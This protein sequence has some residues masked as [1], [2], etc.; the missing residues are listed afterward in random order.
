VIQK[1]TELG[2]EKLLLTNSAYS[3][4]FDFEFLEKKLSRWKKIMASACAQSKNPFLPKILFGSHNEICET[5]QKNSEFNLICLD[6]HM[7]KIDFSNI[8]KYKEKNIIIF[9]GPEGGYS[10]EEIILFE[11]YNIEKINI[12]KYILRTETAS[13]VGAFLAQILCNN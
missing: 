4:K 5:Y 9:I 8:R 12:N 6:P 3:K 1:V 10:N 13:I 2:C 11:K 7:Q